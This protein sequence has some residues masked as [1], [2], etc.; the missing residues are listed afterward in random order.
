MHKGLAI[1]RPNAVVDATCHPL[2]VVR[3]SGS[4]DAADF[5]ALADYFERLLERGDRVVMFVDFRETHRLHLMETTRY[6]FGWLTHHRNVVDRIAAAVVGVV[7]R[8]GVARAVNLLAKLAPLS[9]P[10]RV[11]GEAQRGLDWLYE[12]AAREGLELVD[13]DSLQLA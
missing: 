4:P 9:V 2:L 6:W 12:R 5:T 11:V 1:E 8:K 10:L 13:R 3:L 7:Q